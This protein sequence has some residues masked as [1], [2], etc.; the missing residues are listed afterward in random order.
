MSD[1]DKDG[2]DGGD[3]DGNSL[4]L[5]PSSYG[6]GTMLSAFQ[7]LFQFNFYNPIQELLFA[8]PFD[9]KGLPWRLRW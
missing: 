6:L 5:S 4:P 7:A 2:G 8:P 9:R 1:G 3:E